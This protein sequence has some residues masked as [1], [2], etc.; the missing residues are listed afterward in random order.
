MFLLL[1]ACTDAVSLT[2]PTC[3]VD[4]VTLAPTEAA[5]GDEVVVTASPV[6]ET[7]DTALTV[8]GVRADVLSV[9]RV[10]C[11][12]CDACLDEAECGT[13]STDCDAC[14]AL[15]EAECIETITF[16]VPELAAGDATVELF[17]SHGGSDRLA[18]NVLEAGQAG[19]ADSG[20]TDSGDSGR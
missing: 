4:L 2:L 7:F 6:T 11:D 1:L 8:G 12:A 17:N 15:C 19:G 5:P 18:L 20:A 3:T 9:D 13:C 14:D 16:V 10:G